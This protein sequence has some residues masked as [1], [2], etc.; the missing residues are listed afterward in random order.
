[1]IGSSQANPLRTLFFSAL[2]CAGL[3]AAVVLELTAAGDADAP[4]IGTAPPS[5]PSPVAIPKTPNRFTLAP[6]ESFVEVIERPL[7]SS[8]RRPTAVDA[9][10]SAEQPFNATLAGIVISSTSSSIIVSHGDPPV[11]SRFKEGDSLDGWSVTSI[12]PTRVLLRRDGAERQLKLRDVP[13]Q[14][15]TAGQTTTA[16]P[17][18]AAV[19]PKV[20]TA[21]RPRH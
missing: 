10:E 16:A 18:A 15:T 3:A 12:E 9:P 11:L 14:A 5:P 1:V 21:P 7:F 19:A 17:Q 8:S 13:G 2:L 4:A 20:E 6:Q